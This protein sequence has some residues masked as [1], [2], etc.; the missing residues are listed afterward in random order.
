[1][2]GRTI[3]TQNMRTLYPKLLHWIYENLYVLEVIG[4][5]SRGYKKLGLERRRGRGKEG[6]ERKGELEDIFGCINA[7]LVP[8]GIVCACVR[9][10]G[11]G[12]VV[13][14]VT[15]GIGLSTDRIYLRVQQP[16][17]LPGLPTY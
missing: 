9:A 4:D 11:G 3:Y 8:C 7:L 15:A 10:C 5:M 16:A 6:Q 13:R 17:C 2:L 1:M 14:L 12:L